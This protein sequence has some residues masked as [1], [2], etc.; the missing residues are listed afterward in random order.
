[1]FYVYLIGLLS[2]APEV[3]ALFSHNITNI[4]DLFLRKLIKSLTFIEV[5][6]FLKQFNIFFTI[7]R[8]TIVLSMCIIGV[9]PYA[10][11]HVRPCDTTFIFSFRFRATLK[12]LPNTRFVESADISNFVSGERLT[13]ISHYIHSNKKENSSYRGKTIMY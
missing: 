2:F 8:I 3:F 11:N 4:K 5:F 6:H 12:R 10:V 13:R 1:M 9:I 7:Y